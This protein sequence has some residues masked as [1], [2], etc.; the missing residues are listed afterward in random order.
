MIAVSAII[1]TGVFNGDGEVLR[2]AGPAGLLI[3]LTVVGILV[4]AV[5]E[6]LSELM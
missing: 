6:C 4:V 1:G 5:M 3:A 2:G